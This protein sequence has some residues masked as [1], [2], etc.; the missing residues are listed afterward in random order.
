I[1]LLLTSF[2]HRIIFHHH[3]L[4]IHPIPSYPFFQQITFTSI[5]ISFLRITTQLSIPTL[6]S[7]IL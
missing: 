2:F 4:S 1:E 3:D 5:Q 6:T 7:L